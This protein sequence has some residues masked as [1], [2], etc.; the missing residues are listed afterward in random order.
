MRQVELWII[1]ML[2]LCWLPLL[3]GVQDVDVHPVPPTRDP[4]APGYV[5]ATELPD[6]Q[7]PSKEAPGNFI[8][9][10][11][12]PPT[13]EL[14]GSRILHG[15]VIEFTMESTSSFFYP[16]IAR[17]Q[18]TFGTPDPSDPSSLIV[19]TS[20]PT[21][22]SRKVA[23]YIPKSYVQGT[24]APFI[25]GADGIDR[26][27]FTALDRLIAEHRIPMMI[28]ISIGNGGGDSQGSER[29]LEYD[30]LSGRY[31]EFV[32]KEVLPLVESKGGVRLSND[33]S[34]RATMGTSSG[35]A[36]AFTMAWYHPDL[37]RRVLSYSGTF[38]NQQ[39]PHDPATPH[40]AWEYHERLIPEAPRKPLRLWLEVGDRDLLNLNVMRDGMHDWVEG[41]ERMAKVLAEKG[42]PYQ[43]LF[44]RNAGHGDRFVKFQTLPEALEWLWFD[45]GK[46]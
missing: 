40:G 44:A 5:T 45:Y 9:G 17:D 43:F 27:L 19:T 18:G 36:C 34:A 37:Y 8:L 26:V 35:G 32:E 23:V 31:A 38:V 29:G 30:T 1:L 15:L 6:G 20:H 10:T 41:N 39:W 13:P 4:H 22:Y 11:N 33:P 12:H 3:K 25:V 16:G 14:I 2:Q 28:G 21:P 7:V 42:Y 46:K 24:L